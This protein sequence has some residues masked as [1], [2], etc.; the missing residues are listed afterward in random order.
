MFIALLC[1]LIAYLEGNGVCEEEVAQ[2]TVEVEQGGDGEVDA[3]KAFG[4]CF[5]L[6]VDLLVGEGVLSELSQHQQE[7]NA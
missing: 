5:E 4:H 1:L 7:Q 2:E 6:I 3:E